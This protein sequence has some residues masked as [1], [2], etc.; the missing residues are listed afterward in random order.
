MA[1]GIAGDLCAAL[2]KRV[3][4]LLQEPVLLDWFVQ[5]LLGLKHVH[6]R[7]ILHR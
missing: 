2:K 3:G 7:N 1:L 5:L 6:D 4:A